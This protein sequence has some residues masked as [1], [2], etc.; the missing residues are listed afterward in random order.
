MEL[1][2]QSSVK[3]HPQ[4]VKAQR[5]SPSACNTDQITDT[6]SR[7]IGSFFAKANKARFSL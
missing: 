4:G 6:G 1:A 5:W 7:H 3:L 2:F